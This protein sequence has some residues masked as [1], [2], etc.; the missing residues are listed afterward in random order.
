MTIGTLS[1]TEAMLG[2]HARRAAGMSQMEVGATFLLQ[3]LS[4]LVAGPLVGRVSIF[5]THTFPTLIKPHEKSTA[6]FL[7]KGPVEYAKITHKTNSW[8]AQKAAWSLR[9]NTPYF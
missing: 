3:G 2:A 6:Y 1:F 9:Q 4:F 5:F 7:E 8:R